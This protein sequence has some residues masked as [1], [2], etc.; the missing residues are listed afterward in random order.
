MFVVGALLEYEGIQGLSSKPS[1]SRQRSSS[2]GDIIDAPSSP[3]ACFEA[4][5]KTV[6][7][8]IHSIVQF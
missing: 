3:E 5:V 6:S 8:T 1:M 2:H 7:G 4:L